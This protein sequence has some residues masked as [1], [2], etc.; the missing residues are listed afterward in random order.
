MEKKKFFHGDLG[1]E[2]QQRKQARLRGGDKLLEAG[3]VS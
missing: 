3:I 2:V 1:K